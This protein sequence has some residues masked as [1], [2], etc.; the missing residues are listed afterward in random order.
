MNQWL[1]EK[2]LT[3]EWNISRDDLA[4]M[5]FD[6]KL[7]VYEKGAGKNYIVIPR[8][9]EAQEETE[10]CQY[11]E[12]L[13]DPFDFNLKRST[14]CHVGY[15]L[16]DT[17]FDDCGFR[18][19]DDVV[20]YLDCCGSWENSGFLD[21]PKRVN[22]LVSILTDEKVN[23]KIRFAALTALLPVLL[24]R[25]DD[26][27]AWKTNQAA[28]LPPVKTSADKLVRLTPVQD[29]KWNARE[30]AEKYIRGYKGPT[31]SIK[32]AV[33]IVKLELNGQ[34]P[35][36]EKTIRKWIKDLFPPESRKPGRR[37]KKT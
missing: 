37:P 17:C 14:R 2:D 27:E 1:T 7:K 10:A 29:D 3:F 26:V 25:L 9:T 4:E 6:D 12:R 11:A 8:G 19:L 15:R 31:P 20:P 35:Y 16:I 24:F 13:V 33:D 23:Y 21:E 18:C 36:T 32:E 22:K 30:I 28:A 34:K 5:V